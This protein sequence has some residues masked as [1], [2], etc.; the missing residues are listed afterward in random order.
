[1]E[2]LNPAGRGTG[3]LTSATHGIMFLSIPFLGVKALSPFFLAAVSLLLSACASNMA[4]LQNTSRFLLCNRY[5]EQVL[6]LLESLAANQ[7]VCWLLLETRSWIIWTLAA[8]HD[9]L[10]PLCRKKGKRW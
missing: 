4:S 7:G 1:M 2:R 10:P 5:G 6:V 9:N 3:L 8:A